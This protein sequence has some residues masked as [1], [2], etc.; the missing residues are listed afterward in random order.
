MGL[1]SMG[2]KRVRLNL[3]TEYTHKYIHS[4][5]SMKG[6]LYAGCAKMKDPVPALKVLTVGWGAG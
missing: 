5:N 4:T 2:S 6:Q 1:Q 3:A